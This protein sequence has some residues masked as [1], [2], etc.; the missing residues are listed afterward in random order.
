MKFQKINAIF[1]VWITIIMRHWQLITT[2]KLWYLLFWETMQII[3]LFVL[4]LYIF[5]QITMWDLNNGKLLRTITDVHPPGTAI[6]HVKVSSRG[7][8]S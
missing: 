4:S 3:T 8:L 1:S 6:L 2:Y 7:S 5:T